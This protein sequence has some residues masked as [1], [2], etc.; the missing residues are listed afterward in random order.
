MTAENYITR[1]KTKSVSV[2][3]SKIGGGAKVSIQS[4]T[5]TRTSD[6]F[7]T[8]EQILQL[9]SFGCDIIRVAVPDVE[10]AKALADIKQK[11]HI[12]LV[13]DIHFDYKLALEAIHNGADKIRINPGN[14]TNIKEVAACANAFKVPIRVGVNSGS[15]PNDIKASLGVTPH[16]LVMSAKRYIKMLNDNDFDNI[17]VS[18]KSSNVIDTIA[19]Y[20]LIS[21][22]I[23]YPL[24]L[25]VTEA[26]TT[27]SGSIKSAVGIGSLLADGIGDT[28][29]VTLT[30][31]PVEEVKIAK[32]ILAACGLR[33]NYVEVIACP[34]CARTSIDVIEIANR[35]SEL[36]KDIHFPLTVAIMGCAVNGPGEA[37]HAD[38]GVSGAGDVGDSNGFD[39]NGVLFKKGKVIKTIPQDQI[40]SVL[41]EEINDIVNAG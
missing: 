25:G 15:V 14:I 21:Q 36:T 18:L 38:I 4:M 22:N 12:P 33:D 13:A 16:A 23:D 9:E 40:I 29:R 10:S 37:S 8:V 17:V 3:N 26:G 2:G 32:E 20:R 6:V 28:F 39:G 1:D 19:S 34:T 35:I 11:I 30:A 31:D 7:A 41:M 27:L 5:N 24:H